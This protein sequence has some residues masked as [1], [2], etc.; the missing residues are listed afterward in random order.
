MTK[1]I[2]RKIVLEEFF[3]FYFF[4]SSP[5]RL[6]GVGGV[7]DLYCSQ[8]PGGDQNPRSDCEPK[9]D[10]VHIRMESDLNNWLSTQHIA[11]VQIW[12]VCQVLF[13]FYWMCI[14]FY[15]NAIACCYAYAKNNSNSNTFCNTDVA[16]PSQLCCCILYFVFFVS[17]TF[18]TQ[19][20]AYTSSI[21][22]YSAWLALRNNTSLFLQRCSACFLQKRLTYLRFAW[23][24]AVKNYTKSDLTVQ[25]KS[26][27][28]KC[29]LN[30][31]PIHIRM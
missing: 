23:R 14:G 13:R 9:S 12:F 22:F 5:I 3:Y 28:Q 26:D 11:T 21:L 8:P 6:H 18:K 25:T 16:L 19:R 1:T 30:R 4:Y 20:G 17:A 31:I 7:Y 10:F 2:F 27:F 15:G 29:D 24:E